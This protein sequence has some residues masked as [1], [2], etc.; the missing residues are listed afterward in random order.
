MFLINN[1]SQNKESSD[2]ITECLY[3]VVCNP[4]P[5]GVGREWVEDDNKN[6]WQWKHTGNLTYI[7]CVNETY[8][9]KDKQFGQKIDILNSL[10]I[11]CVVCVLIKTL[12][13][14]RKLSYMKKT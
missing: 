11:T 5:L 13:E 14:A 4:I 8:P 6:E 3:S 10:W 7:H 12:S 9:E 2:I 1:L